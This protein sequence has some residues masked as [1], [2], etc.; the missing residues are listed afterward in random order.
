MKNGIHDTLFGLIGETKGHTEIRSLGGIIDGGKA[1]APKPTG[2]KDEKVA[3][4]TDHHIGGKNATKIPGAHMGMVP[5]AGAYMAR[6][7]NKL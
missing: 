3:D 6:V 4:K 7:G 1:D 5:F 2:L